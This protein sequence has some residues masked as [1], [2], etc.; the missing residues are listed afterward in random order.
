VVNARRRT[1]LF[2]VCLVLLLVPVAPL[3]HLLNMSRVDVQLLPDRSVLATLDL[4]LTVALGGS[5]KFF[6]ASTS[7]S[8]IDD[9]ELAELARRIAAAMQMR[10]GQVPISLSVRDLKMPRQPLSEFVSTLTWPRARLSL[11]GRVPDNVQPGSGAVWVV[12]DPGFP[13]EE[14]IALSIRDEVS[15]RSLSRWLVAEQRSPAFAGSA[16]LKLPPESDVVE[17]VGQSFWQTF[18]QYAALGVRHI[19]PSGI[20]HLLFVTGLF[21]GA[22]RLSSLLGQVSMYTLAHSVTLALATLGWVEIADSFIEPLIALSIAWIAVENWQPRE[23]SG[24]RL[25]VVLLFGLVH[26]FGFAGALRQSGLPADAL[27][28]A[29]AGFNAGVELGQLGWICGLLA[30][31]GRW[32]GHPWYSARVVRPTSLCIGVLAIWWTVQRILA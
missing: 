11:G 5:R 31:A 18:S 8:P 19:L 16:W 15:G 21:L 12:F 25:L 20:D 30:V 10:V 28:A 13:F 29:L 24:R 2:L 4:D 23:A 26:G 9:P 32:R 17:P 1:P 27:P 7:D 14:P 6:E 3:A 22:R